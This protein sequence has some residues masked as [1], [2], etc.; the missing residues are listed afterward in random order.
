[1]LLRRRALSLAV[2]ISMQK[3]F[4]LVPGESSAMLI[5]VDPIAS[6]ASEQTKFRGKFTKAVTGKPP[7]ARPPFPHFRLF[8]APPTTS[9]RCV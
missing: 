7:P 9:Q 6:V 3:F 5:P 1:M 8:P 4:Q 2:E